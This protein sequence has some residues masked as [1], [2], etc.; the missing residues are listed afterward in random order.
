MGLQ[1]YSRFDSPDII[2]VTDL[3]SVFNS[4]LNTFLHLCGSIIKIEKERR[5]NNKSSL[6]FL[7]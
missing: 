3:R 5:P 6:F 4:S 1:F 7:Y 2:A